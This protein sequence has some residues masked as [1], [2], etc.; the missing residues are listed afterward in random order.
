MILGTLKRL[1]NNGATSIMNKS[2]ANI[3]TGFSIGSAN[4]LNETD[5]ILVICISFCVLDKPQEA[6]LVD[7]RAN[8]I[9]LF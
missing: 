4:S 9:K 8:L 5:K 1:S 2:M 7:Y 3:K 6:Q